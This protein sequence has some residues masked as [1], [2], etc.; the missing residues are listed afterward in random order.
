MRCKNINAVMGRGGEVQNR[1]KQKDLVGRTIENDKIY[2]FLVVFA[3]YREISC[4]T[5]RAGGDG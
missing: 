1:E 3:G 5:G 2:N 4:F